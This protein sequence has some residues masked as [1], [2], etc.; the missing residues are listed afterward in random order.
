MESELRQGLQSMSIV[1]SNK[2]IEQLLQYWNLLNKWNRVYN[3]TAIREKNRQ[4]GYHLLDSLSLLPHT[5]KAK[6]ALDVG[7]GA[8]L[9]GLPMAIMQPQCFWVMLDSNHKKTRFVQQAL[10]DCGVD[11]GKVVHARVEDYHADSDLD[12]IVSRGIFFTGRF[13]QLCKTPG[14]TTDTFDNHENPTF[15]S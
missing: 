3:L 5:G 13:C 14:A 9:P 11:N 10:S 2:Q 6:K 8:G 1:A 7:T 4:L 12:V 15:I